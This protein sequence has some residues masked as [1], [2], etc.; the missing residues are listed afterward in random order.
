[1]RFRIARSA[2]PSHSIFSPS[3]L[4]TVVQSSPSHPARPGNSSPQAAATFA[5]GFGG[6]FHR[7]LYPFCFPIALVLALHTN[8]TDSRSHADTITMPGHETDYHTTEKFVLRWLNH[9]AWTERGS[10][11]VFPTCGFCFE[12]NPRVR[13]S[14]LSSR[15]RAA[16]V[17]MRW[18]SAKLI[19]VVS[20]NTWSKCIEFCLMLTT[21]QFFFFV[22][23]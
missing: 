16:P 3:H 7:F 5:H 20:E 18:A 11:P 10:Y 1:M 6:T 21:N 19:T 17:T 22:Q 8:D 23:T 9:L 14:S 2:S 12:I 15:W 13:S 4:L